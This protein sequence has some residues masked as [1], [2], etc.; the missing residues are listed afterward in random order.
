MNPAWYRDFFDGVAV[1]FWV[2]AATPEWTE[3]DVE[4]IWRELALKAGDRVLDCPCGHGRHSV[5]LARRGCQ[6][7][8]VDISSYCLKLAEEAAKAASVTLDLRQADMLE[9][10]SLPQCDAAYTLGNA[11]GY[12]DHAGT[13]QFARGIAAALRPGGRWLI[14]TGVAAESILPNLKPEMEFTLGGIHTRIANK[15]LADKSCLETT[16]VFT[17]DGQTQTQQNWS[18]IFTVAEIRRLLAATGFNLLALYDSPTGGA[19]ALGSGYLYILCEKK[20]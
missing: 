11:F 18:F 17:R 4:M 7:I 3:R 9:L 6:V 2:A 12:L 5:E 8:G 14:D 1:D 20:Q 16:F 13:T 15:Y 10:P 19:Y